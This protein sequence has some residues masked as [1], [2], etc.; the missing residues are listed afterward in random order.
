MAD[1]YARSLASV[2]EGKNVRGEG[3]GVSRL[4]P[5]H[6]DPFDRMLI[7]QASGEELRVISHD[8]IFERYGLSVEVIPPVIV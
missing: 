3:A 6:R 8:K 4:P 1:L 7:A 2:K 5:I